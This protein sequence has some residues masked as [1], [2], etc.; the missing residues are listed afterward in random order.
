MCSDIIKIALAVFVS[1]AIHSCTSVRRLAEISRNR[2]DIDVSI[3]AYEDSGETAEPQVNE[4]SADS[5]GRGPSIMNAVK[6]TET[7]EMVA[8][9]VINASRVVARFRNVAE[10]A[11]KVSIEFDVSVPHEMAGSSW[12]LRIFPELEIMGD[13]VSLEPMLVT[14][15][16][17]RSAQIRGYERYREFLASIITD[18]LDFIM[19]KPLEI[20][21]QRNYPGVYAMKNDT[22]LISDPEAENIF[23]VSQQEVLR[24]YTRFRMA[25]RNEKKKVKSGIMLEK[26]TG[27]I[28]G[29]IRLDTVVTSE[30]EDV[31]YRYTQTL[32]SRPGLKRIPVT[33]SGGVYEDGRMIYRIPGEQRI[34]FYVSSLASLADDTPRYLS[35]IVERRVSDYTNAVLD[36]DKGS[37]RLDTLSEGNASELSRIRECMSKMLSMS[38]YVTDSIVIT[39]SC[40]LEGSARFNAGL[41]KE[42]ARTVAGLLAQGSSSVDAGIFRESSAAENWKLF[43]TISENDPDISPSSLETIMNLPYESDPDGSETVLQ[44]LPEYR[45]LR[46][47][48]YPRL[49]TVRLDFYLHRKD[50]EK[51]TVYTTEVDTVYMKGVKALKDLDY[52]RAVEL[53]GPYRDYNAALAYLSAG[54]DDKALEILG[55]M[56]QKPARVLYLEA[57]AMSRSGRDTEAEELFR[58]CIR[59]DRSML[60]R[61]RLDPEMQKFT[62][63]YDEI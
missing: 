60:H 56:A 5:S 45:H 19:L 23:G 61:G 27:G 34:D 36:F 14:G 52:A 11:G 7:G 47:K 46:E 53:L 3:P 21:L 44:R 26:L 62:L 8:V 51:D 24:H 22:T 16:K 12:Q 6:D 57:L 33:L 18:S 31:C 38:S 42:R 15:A 40:S 49:R 10:R 25:E 17:Y 28:T 2:M 39:A 35:R 32:M 54:Y 9:D 50:M 43:M 1:L 29:R 55:G 48:V 13:T 59:Q 30:G 20:F 41:A 4:E 37:A 63:K 58:Q